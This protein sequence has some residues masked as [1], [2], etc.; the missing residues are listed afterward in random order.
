MDV[1]L[2]SIANQ[3]KSLSDICHPSKLCWFLR[4]KVEVRYMHELN[5][6]ILPS[7]A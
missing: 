7:T 1:L 3:C 4:L 5:P 2:L 6:M